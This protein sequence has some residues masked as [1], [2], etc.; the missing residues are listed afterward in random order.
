MKEILVLLI[1]L[2]S[3]I[4]KTFSLPY[5]ADSEGRCHDMSTEYVQDD[6]N[7]C[8]K[9]CPPGHRLKERCS[10]NTDTVCEPCGQGQYMEQWNYSPNCFS[11]IKCKPTK[12]LQFA[13]HCTT[14]TR[15]KCMCQPGMYCIM[16]FQ[17]PYCSECKPYRPCPTGHGV[18]VPGTAN[19]N[20]ICEQ[21]PNGMF[22]DT[23]SYTDTCRPH[24]DCHGMAV[25]RKG[26]AT[27]DN[28]CEARSP[29]KRLPTETVFTT[30]SMTTSTVAMTSDSTTSPGQE[31]T[32]L[33]SLPVNILT[34]KSP[35]TG[36]PVEL[37]PI[38]TAIALVLLI[39][40]CTLCIYKQIRRRESAQLHPKVD[41]NGNCE[42]A[43][44]AAGHYLVE[45]KMTFTTPCQEQQ[46]LLEKG[47]T[48]SDQSQ[49]STSTE[50]KTDGYSSH[51]SISPSQ[52]TIALDNPHSALSEPM[53]LLSNIDLISSHPSNL[54]QSFSQPSST[55]VI[56]PVATSPHV[57][58]NIT[59]HIG[60]GSCGTPSFM[61]A[62]SIQEDC[63][64]PF[65]EKEESFSI[66]QQEAGKT[67]LMSVQESG[68]YC[69]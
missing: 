11:C 13:Q 52:S 24:T 37:V 31:S 7:L 41:A 12:G 40:I 19:S 66:P 45:S 16:G 32:G 42:S 39:I 2:N 64:V 43:D 5:Q 48:G 67:S 49:Y 22:S 21:C 35:T 68:S 54:T 1:L 69:T 59:L 25:L 15:S 3:R 28:V 63:N 10:Q 36:P 30:A 9:K 51:D 27:S 8:C 55:H 46:C 47:E 44:K 29:T 53:P 61:P 18:S 56:S 6:Y 38:I 20:V 4:T 50:T 17:D 62:D 60:N 65:S 34:T 58:V 26:N 14:T 57:N 33:V 23:V